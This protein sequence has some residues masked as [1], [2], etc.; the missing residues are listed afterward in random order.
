MSAVYINQIACG[1]VMDPVGIFSLFVQPKHVSTR[2]S[3]T[4]V[5]LMLM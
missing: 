1:A 2:V 5:D 4:V 3:A